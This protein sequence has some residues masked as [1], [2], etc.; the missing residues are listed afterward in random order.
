MDEICVA[1]DSD[2]RETS[3]ISELQGPSGDD[4]VDVDVVTGKNR[5]ILGRKSSVKN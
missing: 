4:I 2:L 5:I 1:N 3:T